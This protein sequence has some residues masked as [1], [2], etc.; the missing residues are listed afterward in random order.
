MAAERRFPA[1][2]TEAHVLVVGPRADALVA[3]ACARI[4]QLEA[5]WSRFRPDSE[6]SRLNAAAGAAL[7][8]SPDTVHLVAMA[9]EAWR[10]SAGFVDCTLLEQVVAAGYDRSLAEVPAHRPRDERW[11]PVVPSLLGPLDLQ[12]TATT[13]RLPAGIGFDPGGI[14]KGLAAD[15]V[16][17]ELLA[18]GAEGAC[19][20]L[21]G[22][23]RVGGTGPDGG[24]W[25]VSID[26]PAQRVPVALVG[27]LDGAVATSTTLRR[28]WT[29]GGAERHHLVDPRTGA[30]STSDLTF[31]S[32]VAASAWEAEV[33]AK[34][35]LLR[36]GPYPFDIVEGTGA[37]ALV[38]DRRGRVTASPG[39]AAH[40]GG[41]PLPDHVAGDIDIEV[42][43]L[44]AA[45]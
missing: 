37:H 30:P 12:V 36:G 11:D 9:V 8:V 27:L 38:V 18:A 34:G 20:N 42:A 5:R 22:D 23:V 7:A 10:H 16:V 19:V 31:V 15:L 44:G 26:H 4:D 43:D 28:R 2:G 41:R 21:G 32:V 6:V 24:G 3:D 39:L 1:M 33:L 14:G 13:V 17:A 25:T 35:V 45:S 40:L 29:V